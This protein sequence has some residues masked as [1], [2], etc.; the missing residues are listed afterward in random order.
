MAGRKHQKVADMTDRTNRIQGEGY[1]KRRHAAISDCCASTCVNVSACRM[2]FSES[3]DGRYVIQPDAMS[4]MDKDVDD[5]T[6]NKL[7][8]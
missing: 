6:L 7:Q 8:N 4:Q 3:C 5:A 1:I 2:L